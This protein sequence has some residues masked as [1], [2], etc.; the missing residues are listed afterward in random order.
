MKCCLQGEG[1]D[2]EG[3]SSSGSLPN[4]YEDAW[5]E[6]ADFLCS[7]NDVAAN[8]GSSWLLTL[9]ISLAERHLESS[10]SPPPSTYIQI[11]IPLLISP[12]ECHHTAI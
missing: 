8:L 10:T 4:H 11:H 7:E 12:A 5:K 2:E 1:E 3:V 6:L 9:L